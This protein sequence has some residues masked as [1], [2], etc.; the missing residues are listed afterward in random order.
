VETG[1]KLSTFDITAASVVRTEWYNA[2][3]RLFERYDYLIVPTAQL[4]PFDVEMHW[5]QEIASKKMEAY[6]EWMSSP[7]SR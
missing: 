4:F 7:A 2:V 5:P 6:H 1:L 3:R